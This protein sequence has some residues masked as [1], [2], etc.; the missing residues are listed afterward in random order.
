VDLVRSRIRRAVVVQVAS[1]AAATFVPAAGVSAQVPFSPGPRILHIDGARLTGGQFVYETVLEHDI[2]STALGTRTVSAMPTSY[3][4]TMAWLLLESKYGGSV[5]ALDSLFVEQGTLRPLHW[6]SDIGR[7]HLGLEFRND[8]AFGG[9]TAPPGRQ[10]VIAGL[11]PGTLV[12]ASMLE[13]ALRTL[14]LNIAWEDS[15]TTL[16]VSLNGVSALPARVAVIGEDYVRVP[17]GQFDCWVVSVRA[18]DVTRGMYWVTKT[19]PIIVRSALDVPGL[20]GAQY[21]S[22]LTSILR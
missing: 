8:S 13:M 18:A 2:T 5:P 14:P 9:T 15:A 12:N 10:S 11:P 16:S 20:N 19:D 7:A 1:I 17:A 22:S 21:V 3:N 6:S 4:G